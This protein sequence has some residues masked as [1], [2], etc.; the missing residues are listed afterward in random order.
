MTRARRVSV[1]IPVRN[2]GVTLPALLAGLGPGDVELI[3]LDNASTDDSRTLLESAGARVLSVPEGAFDHGETRNRGAREAEGEFV[4]FLSQDTRPVGP[5]F[6]DRLVAPLERDARLAGA[7]ARQ[8]PRDDADARTRRDLRG[9]VAGQ[10]EARVV[11]LESPEALARLSPLE[12][13]RLAAFDN[14][15]SVV[16]RS[17][18]LEHPFPSSRFGED[19]EWSQ[20]VLARGLG[21]AYVPEAVVVHSHARTARAL[22]RR[23]YLGHRLFRRLFG[24]VTVPDRPHLVRASCGAV[25]SDLATLMRE[26]ASASAWLAAPA[27]AVAATLG[28]YR[29][30]RDET[31][32]RPYPE[33]A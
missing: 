4:V 3:A 21:I 11:F 27:Q 24:L 9:W 15:A 17:T 22:Y 5:G 1:V 14:V 26:G 18:L 25:M 23:N 12:R 20:A 28:Q 13:L 30:A 2:G 33:W 19:L 7:F 8:Q 16:R 6:T 31:N 10:H 29:G 32:G